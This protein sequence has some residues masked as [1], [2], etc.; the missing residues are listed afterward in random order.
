MVDSIKKMVVVV[1]D[2]SNQPP[3]DPINISPPNWESWMEPS[4][5]LKWKC[6][7]TDDQV[8]NFD[9][10]LGKT[11]ASMKSVQTGITDFEID[12]NIRVYRTTITGLDL[13]QTYFW[14]VYARDPAGNYTP[15]HI[16][17]FTTRP[18]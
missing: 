16:W 13:N 5:I 4:A 18:E 3:N 7:D 6:T 10:W 9:L 1:L 12:N 17:R 14:R 15:G 8:L 2:L 11:E